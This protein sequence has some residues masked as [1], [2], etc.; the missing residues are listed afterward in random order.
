MPTSTTSVAT[1]AWNE[2]ALE[3]A[4]A[5]CQQPAYFDVGLN[6]WVL[7]RHADVFAALREPALVPGRSLDPQ[8][9]SLDQARVH[10]RARM[11]AETLE[12]LGPL[13]LAQWREVL[14]TEAAVIVQTLPSEAVVDLMEA[15]ARP[16]C[17]ALAARVTG[18]SLQ[19]AI[20]LDHHARHISAAAA[21][22][23]DR[24][25]SVQAKIL[26]E[27]IRS[28][29]QVGPE[30]LRD[31][32]FVALSQTLA[33][34]LTNAW[35]ALIEHPQEWQRLHHHPES[36]EAAIEELLRYAGLV[37]I[38]FRTASEDFHLNGSAIRQ[39]DHL[40]LRIVA[41]NRDPE[42]YCCPHQVEI[43]RRDGGHLALGSGPHACVAANLIRMAAS[44]ITGPL[45]SQFSSARLAHPV[46]WLGGAV[47]RAPQSLP[48][49]LSEG[50]RASYPAHL[51]QRQA[52][53]KA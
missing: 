38:L 19:Q 3:S 24:A 21:D 40:V 27:E 53:G 23:D 41:A 20:S 29:F 42:R 22:P 43:T 39:G 49:T 16:L 30:A 12:A 36:I 46:S 48:A 31:S 50:S 2:D 28:E 18:I 13:K 5:P 4:V 25:L 52:Q 44:A 33:F 45:L 34:L 10:L 7:S 17:L 47:F 26:N 11:R 32:G 14:A 15:Y 51:Q 9:T 8:Q 37:R 1:P 6:A 35:Y